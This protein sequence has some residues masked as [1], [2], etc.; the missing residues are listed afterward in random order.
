MFQLHYVHRHSYQIVAF[1][2]TVLIDTVSASYAI[3][4]STEYIICYVFHYAN[5][6]FL[7]YTFKYF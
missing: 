1:D 6:C 4:N 3:K 2:A 7:L 5:G